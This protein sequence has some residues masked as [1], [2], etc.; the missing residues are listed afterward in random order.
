MIIQVYP[1]KTSIFTKFVHMCEIYVY[2]Y[3]CVTFIL[4]RLTMPKNT[5][6]LPFA[7]VLEQKA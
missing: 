3:V 5:S 4:I 7:K 6:C 2:L 1:S